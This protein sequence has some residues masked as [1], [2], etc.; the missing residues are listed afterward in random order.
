MDASDIIRRNL[1]VVRASA[2]VQAVEAARPTFIATTTNTQINVS[3]LSFTS[4]EA[5]MNFDAGMKYLS[6]TN[7]T[8]TVSTMNF[9]ASRKD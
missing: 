7:G 3:T 9:C 1:Q 8:P 4:A 5:K 6:F 2:T